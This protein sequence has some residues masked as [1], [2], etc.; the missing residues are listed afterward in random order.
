MGEGLVFGA[1]VTTGKEV[2]CGIAVGVVDPL[3]ALTVFTTGFTVG[4]AVAEE[5]GLAVP[6]DEGDGVAELTD[7]AEAVGVA[8]LAVVGVAVAADVGVGVA[9]GSSACT[10]QAKID[11]NSAIESTK[12]ADFVNM[13]Q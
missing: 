4:L 7:V 10:G 2:D 5:E 6:L 8:E 3:G 9:V 12:E 11:A 13:H 1:E